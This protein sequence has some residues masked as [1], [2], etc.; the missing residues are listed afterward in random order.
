MM[1]IPKYAKY[2]GT[3]EFFPTSSPT[4]ATTQ[5]LHQLFAAQQHQVPRVCVHSIRR[6][7]HPMCVLWFFILQALCACS[8]HWTVLSTRRHPAFFVCSFVFI[9]FSLSVC[10][11]VA[12]VSM[13]CLSQPSTLAWPCT[14]YYTAV[15]LVQRSCLYRSFV[16]TK[17]ASLYLGRMKNQRGLWVCWMLTS[18]KNGLMWRKHT[19]SVRADSSS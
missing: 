6:Q 17:L 10:I 12:G 13:L 9:L 11:M 2:R 14:T 3:I 8:S 16:T 7:S 15:Y 5:L 4:S 19:P 1:R 18:R